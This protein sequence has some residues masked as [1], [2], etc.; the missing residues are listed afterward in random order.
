MSTYL[1]PMVYAL[2]IAVSTL[3]LFTLPMS[4]TVWAAAANPVFGKALYTEC[5][6]CH[7]V[8]RN[9][10]GPKLC[11]LIGR[12]AASV[13]GYVYSEAMSASGLVWND[14]TLDEYLASPLDKV[15][16]SKM[17]YA[18]FPDPADR[19]ELIEYLKVITDPSKCK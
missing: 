9:K 15:P 10:V 8:A 14:K 6:G 17:E 12:K 16:E 18:G 7:A 19:F 13:T 2:A 11:G 1:R 3:P 4:T 5:E